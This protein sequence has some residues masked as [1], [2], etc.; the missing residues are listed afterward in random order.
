MTEKEF[1]MELPEQQTALHRVGPFNRCPSKT[2]HNFSWP[3][4]AEYVDLH[5]HVYL[6][7]PV[8]GVLILLNRQTYMYKDKIQSTLCQ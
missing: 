8:Q 3:L 6:E 4:K 7:V 1:Y 5:V 2:M